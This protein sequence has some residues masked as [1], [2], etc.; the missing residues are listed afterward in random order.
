M[1]APLSLVFP[2]NLHENGTCTLYEQ[3][4]LRAI[5]ILL[6]IVRSILQVDT[7]ILA[8]QLESIA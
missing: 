5:P 1:A 6:L 4:I 7:Y 8:K 2:I 3:K